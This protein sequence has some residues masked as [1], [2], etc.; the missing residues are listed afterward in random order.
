LG[1]FGW[2]FND[3]QF[4]THK[5]RKLARAFPFGWS[6]VGYDFLNHPYIG[7]LDDVDV[8]KMQA[9]A[10]LLFGT[11]EGYLSALFSGTSLCS[12]LGYPREVVTAL[13]VA[14]CSAASG[15]REEVEEVGLV[16]LTL[17]GHPSVLTH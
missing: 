17:K 15:A 1:F 12:C 3:L 8:G 4:E 2:G 14:Q 5:L 7:G 11:L 16:V 9:P 10:T 13:L 6:P